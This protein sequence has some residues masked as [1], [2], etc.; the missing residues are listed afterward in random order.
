MFVRFYVNIPMSGVTGWYY[1]CCILA[2]GDSCSTE[3]DCS[4]V[5]D[6][7]TCDSSS[8]CACKDD[9]KEQNGDCEAEGV[10]DGGG[11]VF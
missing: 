3:D 5:I 8:E 7:S 4:S 2:I 6:H 10:G 1:Y 11:I 9:Y